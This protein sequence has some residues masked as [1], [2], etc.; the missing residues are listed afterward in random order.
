LAHNNQL[1]FISQILD[2]VARKLALD[3]EVDLSEY[4]GRTAGFSSAD[5]QALLYNAHLDA[6][7][8]SITDR[9]V[10]T[11]NQHNGKPARGDSPLKV[12]TLGVSAGTAQSK[13]EEQALQRRVCTF[14]SLIFLC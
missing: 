1:I 6:I 13:A 7:H 11:G 4:A 3:A 2:V 8:E 14:M 5:L 10:E 9:P 12:V